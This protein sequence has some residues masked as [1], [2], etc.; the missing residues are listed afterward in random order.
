MSK[1]GVV[2]LSEAIQ[3]RGGRRRL[4]CGS[5]GCAESRLPGELFCASCRDT[6]W[7]EEAA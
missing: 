6:V 4:R 2:P 7:E 3:E 1:G 5:L